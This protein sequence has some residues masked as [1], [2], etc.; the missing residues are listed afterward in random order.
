ME[1][2]MIVFLVVGILVGAGVGI[3]VGYVMFDEDNSDIRTEYWFYL[4][5]GTGDGNVTGWYSGISDSPFGGFEAAMKNGGVAYVVKESSTMGKYIDSI[6]GKA[7]DADSGAYW[8]FFVADGLNSA[9]D[10]V[11][12]PFGISSAASTIFAFWFTN[13]TGSYVPANAAWITTGPFAALA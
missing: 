11:E 8:K 7:W 12:S 10:W 6:N 13:S 5:D 9:A 1:K 4:D 3:G 2:N